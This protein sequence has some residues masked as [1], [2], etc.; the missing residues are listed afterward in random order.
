MLE[1]SRSSKLWKEKKEEKKIRPIVTLTPQLLEKSNFAAQK[2][3]L[4]PK[5]QSHH[6]HLRLTTIHIHKVKGKK[7]A[8]IS[9][10]IF[11]PI[12]KLFIA[13]T[14]FFFFFW[15]LQCFLAPPN[16]PRIPGRSFFVNQHQDGLAP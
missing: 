13:P 7:V 4:S 10:F 8:E 16:Q 1:S 5:N 15:V 11:L 12:T 3:A 2:A 6:E 9:K 14:V